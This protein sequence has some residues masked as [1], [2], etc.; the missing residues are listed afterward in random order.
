MQA[1]RS[2]ALLS[3]LAG[4]VLLVVG[5]AFNSKDDPTARASTTPVTFE[6]SAPPT[7][8]PRDTPTPLPPE[9]PTPTPTPAP[10]DGAVARLKIPRFGVD[11]A[12]ETIGLLPGNTLDT[13][14]N[15]HNTGWYDIYDKPGF[16]GNAVFSAHVDYFPNILGPFNKLSKSDLGDEIIVTMENGLEYHY[17]II[18][19][20]RYNV[21]SI[22][23]G[24]LIWPPNKPGEVEWITLITCGGEFRAT[25]SSGAG[26]YLQRDVVVAERIKT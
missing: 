23:M 2:L 5:F 15:P 3:F 10:Y 12:I 13:P 21:D 16:G 26:E 25:S 11:S 17:K 1:L 20:A 22:P 7:P 9:A 14:H 8:T 24:E 18:R 19:K 6:I 4:L